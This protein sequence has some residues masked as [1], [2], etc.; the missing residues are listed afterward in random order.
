MKKNREKV[1]VRTGAEIMISLVI[2][3]GLSIVGIGMA[4]AVPTVS[5][6]PPSITG[7]SPSDTFSINVSVDPEE[8]G[9][10]GCKI[11]LTYNASA[12][13]VTD[14]DITEREL[15]SP[16][17]MTEPGS[18][19]KAPG[20]IHY[21]IV[22]TPVDTP[23][24]TNPGTFIT[25]TFSVNSGAVEDIYTLSLSNVTLNNE[26]GVEIPG[27]EVHGGNV[28]IGVAA[29]TG[30]IIIN[31]IMY[32][33][34]GSEYQYE[35]VELYNN[36]T[37]RINITDWTIDGRTIS[38]K[39][40]QPEDY[41]VLSEN[42]TAFESRYGTLPCVMEVGSLTFSNTAED[43]IVL[44][45]ATEVEM[46][47]VTYDPNEPTAPPENYTLELNATG[48]WESSLVDGGTPCQPNS[49]L[50]P[51]GP[52]ETAPTTEVTIPPDTTPIPSGTVLG[53][54]NSPV[55]LSFRRD[56][57]GGVNNTGVAYTNYSMTGATTLD[58][59][60]E[61]GEADFTTVEITAEGDT[62]VWYYSVDNASN[63][64]SVELGYVPNVTVRV[65]TTPPGTVTDLNESAVDYTWI[66]WTWT[67]PIDP[68]SSGFDHVEVWLDGDFKETTAGEEYKAEGLE[69]NTT[70][71]ISV[72]AVDIAGNIGDWQN[73]TAKTLADT[74]PPTAVA[75]SDQ[76]V[77]VGDTVSFDGSGSTDNV[78]IVT[79]EWDFG[80][81]STGTTSVTT[82]HV[83]SS[84]GAYTVT[85]TV[86]DGVGLNN[87]DKLT[88]TV[89]R[90]PSGG[91]GGGAPRD[92]DG[93]GYTDIQEMLAETDK[94][95]PCD[96]NP[97]CAAC[98]ATKPAA[99]PTPTP[100]PT[101]TPTAKPTTP[102][103][104]TPKPTAE[105]EPTA[106][107]EPPGFEAVFAIAGLLAVAYLVLRR[108][109]K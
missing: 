32:N 92:T 89:N 82:A 31:E 4:S 76:T 12:F 38:E 60:T 15:I 27:V 14:A 94:N 20:W 39:T 48:G 58:W 103:A 68:G 34:E 81:G 45:N 57:S 49:V 73:D 47:S 71:E 72:R 41:V 2:I 98:L 35:W 13:T 46:D 105:P 26:S 51:P 54:T 43:T 85:L 90:R 69:T 3:A 75:G 93:D 67:N 108:K 36:D 23:V 25:V 84:A 61:P 79:Y 100:T 102:P 101:A 77:Y 33:P 88:V 55:M 59:Q 80:D 28:T 19:V 74:E 42:K 109:R 7:L 53:W 17:L 64:E 8:Y 11:D 106:T 66:Q 87:S 78:E 104:P 16:K 9:V 1:L 10:L 18:G 50:G 91:G 22:R 65:D 30:D 96:P 40:M 21:G 44:E 5:I 24:P 29:T 107:P 99:T 6:D 86:T 83:Y 63:N 52:D 95:D 56:D 70:Y 37:I 62:T 97:E